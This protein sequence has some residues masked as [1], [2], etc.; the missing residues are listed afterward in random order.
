MYM[1]MTKIFALAALLCF[2]FVPSFP[3]A[4]TAQSG[5]GQDIAKQAEQYLQR[6]G[7]AQARFLQTAPDGNQVIGTFYL[8]RPGRL[9]FEYDDPIED[10]IVADGL[11][12]YFYDADLGQ[13]TNAPIGQTLADFL[14]RSDLRFS[15]DVV[16]SDIRESHDLHQITLTQAAD[17]AAGAITLGF[18]KEP[19][20]LKK[21]HVTD[22]TGAVTEIELFQLQ[23][24]ISLERRLFIYAD[25]AHGRQP[26]YNE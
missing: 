16:V 3:Y 9:R 7:T 11:L 24:G 23:T 25:P 17:P 1:A 6:L 2:L 5:A 10:F 20:A 22:A 19:F 14:L 26:R 12:I 8:S 13:Q 21:W 15:G 18:T 4:A